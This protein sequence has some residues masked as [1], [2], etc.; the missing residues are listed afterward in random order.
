MGK[1]MGMNE[2]VVEARQKKQDAKSSAVATKSKQEEDE[3]WSSHANPKGKK[4]AKREDEVR[5]R[6]LALPRVWSS[7]QGPRSRPCLPAPATKISTLP[8]SL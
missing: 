3:Y 8:P 4:D 1:K 2:K 6:F 5:L 7:P